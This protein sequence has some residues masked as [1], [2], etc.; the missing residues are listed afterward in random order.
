MENL[1]LA[2]D[3]SHSRIA[4]IISGSRHL[5][6]EAEDLM[7]KVVAAGWELVYHHKLPVWLQDNEY[8]VFGHRQPLNS[9]RSCF[10]SVFKIH[11][12]T[13]NIWT[14]LLGNNEYLLL[15]VERKIKIIF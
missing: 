9:F 4:G 13:G 10:Q 3:E 15:V 14:H 6:E 12:E 8:I 5:V 7:K 11:T 1:S 2:E